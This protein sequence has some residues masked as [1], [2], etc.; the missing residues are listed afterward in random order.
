MI[1][2][3]LNLIL[4]IMASW[5]LFLLLSVLK[6]GLI[7][8]NFAYKQVLCDTHLESL[9]G[10]AW[11][12]E[13]PEDSIGAFVWSLQ[14]NWASLNQKK[15]LEDARELSNGDLLSQE[16]VVLNASLTIRPLPRS[17]CTASR[18]QTI[19]RHD[20]RLRS[21]R[22]RSIGSSLHHSRLRATRSMMLMCPCS[23][24]HVPQ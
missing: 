22:R 9:A 24:Q 19:K 6:S 18:T 3:K 11:A 13:R 7:M 2:L 16:Q 20:A 14:D 21:S 8:S 15:V 10:R 12:L 17:T 1:V 4:F 23:L 5:F